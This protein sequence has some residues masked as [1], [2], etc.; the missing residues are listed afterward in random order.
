MAVLAWAVRNRGWSRLSLHER[1]CQDYEAM[2]WGKA[3]E[4]VERGADLAPDD[5][6]PD[7]LAPT[8]ID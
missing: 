4:E 8:K 3:I 6:S 1:Y 2:A 7:D 5:P